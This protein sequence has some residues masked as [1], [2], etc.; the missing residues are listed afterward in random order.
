MQKTG[1][2]ADQTEALLA[3]GKYMPVLSGNVLPSALPTPPARLRRHPGGAYV[4]GPIT[5]A[6]E[7]Q[8][9][10]SIGPQD[11]RG[12]H[13]QSTSWGRYQ[14]MHRMIRLQRWTQLPFDELD[15]LLMAVVRREADG[16]PA[17][18]SNDNTLRALGVYR[19]LER[20]RGLSLQAFAA[21]L[22]EIPVRAPGVRLSLYD[23]LFN[24]APLPG[25]ALTLD[26]LTLALR[27]E[28]PTHLR[29]HLCAGLHLSDSPDSL[30]WLIKQARLH[31]PAACPT[32]TFY[33][34]LY[35][36]ARIAQLFGLSV[37]ESY[38]VAALLGGKDYTGQLVNPSLRRSGV[39][40][41][42]D[43]L[44]VLMQMDWLVRWLNDTG[45]TVDQLRRQLLLD[46]QSPPPHV[47]TYITQLD[48]VVELTR[49][50]L[51]AQE[52]LADLSLPQPEPDT[53]AAPIAWH[54]LIVQGLLHSQP[55]LKPAPPKELPNGLVQLIEAQ[56]LSLNPE[57]NT[58]L[59]SDA[60]QAV[61]K[62]L[63]AF[64]QQMQPLKAKI[65]T[66]L[67][68]PHTLPVTPPRTCNGANSWFGKL[69]EPPLP[70]PPRSCTIM[71]C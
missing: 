18:P 32:L 64:Y 20:R 19:Y 9:P 53:K 14:R 21:V 58:A 28:I 6:V 15:A 2:T 7:T 42:A 54:A 59:H 46:A 10:L 16:D 65:D 22:D 12:V 47:Q 34:A 44:D 13:L 33:S 52:D 45:Q 49:H 50:G 69:P 31:L 23:E 62:K 39:N 35:R 1:L 29:H 61:T 30:H 60:K 71:Y 70:N 36:Q 38:H 11:Q 26:R 57:R 8:T 4:N 25:Q 67:N 48:E 43:L 17:R 5:T 51:L 40:A 55:L 41:P 56:T 63:G 66:L 37:L 3:C 68:A 24:P 27:E